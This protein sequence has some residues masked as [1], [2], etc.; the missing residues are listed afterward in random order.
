MSG[1]SHS[2]TLI[3]GA[4]V[5]GAS[6]AYHLAKGA[7]HADGASPT[8]TVLD[9]AP[10]PPSP[11]ASTDINKIVRADYSSRF[12]ADLAYEA[13]DAWQTWPELRPFYHRTGWVML[14]EAGS[15]L[16]ERIRRV[17]RD[18]GH[19][20]TSDVPLSELGDRDLWSG[21]LAGTETRGI[22]GAY[23]NPEAG[24]CDAAHATAAVM[25]AAVAAGVRYECGD[26]EALLLGEERVRGVKTTDGRVRTAD[27]VVLATG[28]WTSSLL[29]ATED[30]LGMPDG[31]R[32]EKQAMAAGVCVAHYKMSAEEMHRLAQ[33]PVVVYGEHGEAI[34]PPTENRLLKFT[35]AH[36]FTNTVTTASGRSISAP[37]DRDQHIVPTKLQRETQALM[38]SRVMPRFTEGK[39]AAYWRLCWDARTPSQDWLLDRHPHPRL[40]NLYL[41]IGGSF[42]SYKFLP[43]AGKY[44][45]NVLGGAG[46]GA[47]KDKAWG[48]KSG[49]FTGVGAHEKT[50]PKRELRDLDDE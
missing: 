6:T 19:D 16:A 24:W 4:G 46:N 32:V 39:T 26:V 27:K 14:D 36:T 1:P 33:M 43:T 3:I 37:P 5:F 34:P 23:W 25:E 9:R 40:R 45:A 22:R 10:Y 12:Y 17:F 29:T 35:N 30:E 21:V 44:M 42:H 48:W 47:E 2:S 11:A 15:D 13:I 41:A 49:G 50:A 20:P 38:M 28:A 31:D 7:A 18:R 8:I